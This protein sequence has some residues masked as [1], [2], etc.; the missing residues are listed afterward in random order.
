MS[1]VLSD[2]VIDRGIHSEVLRQAQGAGTGESTVS[3][4]GQ[5][6]AVSARTHSGI[7]TA[8]ASIVE[9]APYS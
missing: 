2:P 3:A 1:E 9:A 5:N 8:S 7:R 4:P 6:S